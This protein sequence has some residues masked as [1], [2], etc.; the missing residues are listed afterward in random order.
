MCVCVCIQYVYVFIYLFVLIWRTAR[1]LLI[2]FFYMNTIDPKEHRKIDWKLL[3]SGK[4][5][6]KTSQNGCFS[7]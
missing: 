3:K 4:N 5:S 1:W 2:I 6:I 7:P